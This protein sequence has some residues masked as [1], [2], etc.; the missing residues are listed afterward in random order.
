MNFSYRAISKA[1]HQENGSIDAPSRQVAMRSLVAE[2]KVVFEL[3]EAFGKTSLA[4]FQARFGKVFESRRHDVAAMFGDLAMLTDAGLT[5]SQALQ[6]MRASSL[7]P[8]DKAAV[9]SVASQMSAGQTAAKA[10]ASV[11]GVPAF[12]LA[13]I[14]SGENAHSLPR[15]FSDIA[16]H[17]HNHDKARSAVL[18]ALAYPGFLL[19]LMAAALGVVTFLLVPSIEP[20]FVNNGKP[21]P[22]VIEAFAGL[23]VFLTQFGPVALFGAVVLAVAGSL[24]PVR[25]LISERVALVAMRLPIVG[26]LVR[27]NG[28]ARYLSSLAMLLQ[29]GTRMAQALSLAA[30]SAAV[31]AM[32]NRLARVCD[33]V[34]AGKRLPQALHETGLFDSRTLSL[35]AVGYDAGKLP[36]VAA[37]AADLIEVASRERLDRII[38]VLTPSLTIVMGLV[39]GGLVVSVM[40]AL[41]AINELAVQ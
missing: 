13:M 22:V 1:G 27:N 16:T 21:L 4:I 39:I 37:K 5:I 29:N 15:V 9:K 23:R 36:Q 17:M 30:E 35:I 41:L 11:T 34:S 7:N 8:A 40:T 32:T 3:Q 18:N 25:K 6:S 2:G 24:L 14:S 33:D 26:P 20:V 19:I 31:P 12:A 28:L 10:F 38:A